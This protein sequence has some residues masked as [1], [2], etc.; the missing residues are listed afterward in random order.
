MRSPRTFDGQLFARVSAFFMLGLL[1]ASLVCPGN[2]EAD[3][4]IGNLPATPAADNSASAGLNNLNLKAILFTMGAADFSAS[5][6][7]LRLQSYNLAGEAVVEIHAFTG[8]TTTVGTT[9]LGFTAPAP[10]GSGV[11][12]YTFNASS[13]LTLQA[14]TSYWLVVGGIV[15]GSFD[16]RATTTALDPYLGPATYNSGLSTSNGGS[17]WNASAARN[18]FQL[19]GTPIPEPS[20]LALVLF[21]AVPVLFSRRSASR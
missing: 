4:I 6:V 16:W 9:L 7:T 10:G 21:G 3:L 20:A 12:E 14:N 15:S 8:S 19:N 11:A 2:A 17:S 18:Y 1:A 13:S 5:D